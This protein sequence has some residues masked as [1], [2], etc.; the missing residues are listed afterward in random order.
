MHY[1]QINKHLL[2][3]NYDQIIGYNKLWDNIKNLS[4]VNLLK[5]FVS[6]FKPEIIY[7]S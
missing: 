7:N 3:F 2:V 1:S 4:S 5:Y 6:V